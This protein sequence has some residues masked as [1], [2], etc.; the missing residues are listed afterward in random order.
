M[1]QRE[2]ERDHGGRTQCP[3]S[4]A[5]GDDDD[6][7]DD[8]RRRQGLRRRVRR[9]LL[10]G[11]HGYRTIGDG[12]GGY[13]K[14]RERGGEGEKGEEGE[15]EWEHASLDNIGFGSSRGVNKQSSH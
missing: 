7:D 9:S 2:R 1:Q 14:E 5:S 12:T 3:G 10:P 15:R 13:V 11:C 6:D 4:A 8:G